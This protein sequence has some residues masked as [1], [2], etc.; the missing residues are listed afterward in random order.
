MDTTS[1]VQGDDVSMYAEPGAVVIKL[2]FRTAIRFW[3][4][5]TNEYRF[6]GV[7]IGLDLAVFVLTLNL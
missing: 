2:V 4:R 5:V 7:L 1:R 3:R 6:C